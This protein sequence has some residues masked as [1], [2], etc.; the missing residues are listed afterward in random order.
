MDSLIEKITLYDIMSYFI[1]GFLCLVLLGC[2][3]YP[4]LIKCNLD[5]CKDYEGFLIFIFLIFSYVMGIALS[6]ISRFSCEVC[7][8]N[9]EMPKLLEMS[10]MENTLR[11]SLV[12][13]GIPECEIEKVL[14]E[15]SNIISENKDD[16]KRKMKKDDNST[17]SSEGTW[18]ILIQTYYRWI[19]SDI[20]TDTQYK[21]IHNYASSE[22]M[23]K[24]IAFAFIL[25]AALPVFSKILLKTQL[26]YAAIPLFFIE[27]FGALIFLFRWQGFSKKKTGYALCW[28]MEK[29]SIKDNASKKN[30]I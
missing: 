16:S 3:F 2:N 12:N 21:R 10:H 29:Y 4:E 20:Q 5:I 15:N 8:H 28:F 1:P 25:A 22:S 6:S 7:F 26:S 30:K 23:Y 18:Q 13:S 27:Y 17:D 14:T 24:N 19:Y 11:E 9:S